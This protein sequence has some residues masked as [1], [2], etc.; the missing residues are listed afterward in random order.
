MRRRETNLEKY[1]IQIFF[2]PEAVNNVDLSKRS[3]ILIEMVH[4]EIY[5]MQVIELPALGNEWVP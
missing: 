4:Q 2:L 3:G 5:I 1:P